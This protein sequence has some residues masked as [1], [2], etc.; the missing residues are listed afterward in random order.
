MYWWPTDTSKSNLMN[1][2]FSENCMRPLE[3]RT[4]F[5]IHF[6]TAQVLDNFGLASFHEKSFEDAG[7]EP[8]TSQSRANSVQ[9]KATTT[10][11]YFRTVCSKFSLIRTFFVFSAFSEINSS[12]LEAEPEKRQAWAFSSELHFRWDFLFCNK[13]TATVSTC[14]IKLYGFLIYWKGTEFR[15]SYVIISSLAVSS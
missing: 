13:S 10:A 9:L 2:I 12:L 5:K 3:F 7:I 11:K 1:C 4:L 14:T 8:S 15:K 6:P